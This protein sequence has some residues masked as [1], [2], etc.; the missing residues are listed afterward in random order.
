MT[1]LP[2]IQIRDLTSNDTFGA[3][4]ATLIVLAFVSPGSAWVRDWTTQTQ[5]Q[6]FAQGDLCPDLRLNGDNGLQLYPMTGAEALAYCEEDPDYNSV[7]VL[8]ETTGVFW[9]SVVE[10]P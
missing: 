2:E 7:F 4:P 8:D 3:G 6:C 5:G 10:R 9:A 1:T